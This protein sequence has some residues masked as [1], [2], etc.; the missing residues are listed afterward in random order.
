MW[1]D[2]ISSMK[3][4]IIYIHGGDSFA[5]REDFLTYLKTTPLRDPLGERTVRWPDTLRTDLGPDYEVYM[6][7]M[8][9]KFNARFD[10]WVIWM[11]RYL[12]LV[13]DGVI[14]I[15]WSLGGMFLAKYLSETP[16]K[17]QVAAAYLLAAPGGEFVDTNGSGGDCIDF[18]PHPRAVATLSTLIPRLEIW[19]SEDDFVVPASEVEWYRTHVPGATITIFKDK[20]HF[21]VESLPELIASIKA[22]GQ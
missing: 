1:Y 17:K 6:P 20:N 19:Q 8:P 12:D 21:L 14:L 11:E 13:E 22:I 4:Q 10:E 5:R 15:G 7:T 2:A 3:R 16:L 9:N 18:R